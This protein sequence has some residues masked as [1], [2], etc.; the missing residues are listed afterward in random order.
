MAL[1][2]PGGVVPA[3]LVIA[4]HTTRSYKNSENIT[5]IPAKVHNSAQILYL[6]DFI[7]NLSQGNNSTEEKKSGGGGSHCGLAETNWTW[8]CE[9]AGSIPG[10]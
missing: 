9:E 5:A 10:L 7:R 4:G 6:S 8:I 1:P 3:P 2:G